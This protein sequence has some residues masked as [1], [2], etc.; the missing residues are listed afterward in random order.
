MR[1][2]KPPQTHTSSRSGAQLS[3]GSTLPLPKRYE[4]KSAK[5]I[6]TRYNFGKGTFWVPYNAR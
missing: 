5:L 3:T 1:G 2:A 6:L 4:L